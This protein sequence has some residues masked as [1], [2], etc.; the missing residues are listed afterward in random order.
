[1]RFIRYI[2]FVFVA[3]LIAAC[4]PVSQNLP[5]H[6]KAQPER[7]DQRLGTQW[8]EGLLSEV[9]K[10][11]LRRVSNQPLD[12]LAI[13]YSKAPLQGTTV[14][15]LILSNG[16]IGVAILNEKGEK[17][18]LKQKDGEIH[19]QGKEGERYQLFYRNYDVSNIYEII[20][21]VDGL[22]VINGRPGS[23]NNSGYALLPQQTL[24]I[25]GFRKS[26]Q[27]VAAFRFSAPQQSYNANTP[28][29]D[30]RN[31][32]ILGTVIF[33]VVDPSKPNR[34]AKIT[35]TTR[36]NPFPNEKGYAPAPRYH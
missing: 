17:I 5:I 23:F 11:N 3:Y 7:V 10:V 21:T 24:T 36:P 16:R 19:L 13:S 31:I 32:G 15:E 26:D 20:A 12:T 1:M 28:M 30:I 8:G 18:P 22:D 25:S 4:T 14:N 33:R 34:P 29:G 35:N 27:E 6:K 2:S 9:Y